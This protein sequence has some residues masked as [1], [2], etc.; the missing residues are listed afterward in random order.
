VRIHFI[1]SKSVASLSV[2]VSLY[3]G[4]AA[5]AQEVTTGTPASTAADVS[6]IPPLPPLALLNSYQ[7]MIVKEIR[8]RGIGDDRHEVKQIRELVQQQVG[9]P[10]DR[11][12]VRQSLKS[13]Y[14]TGRFQDLIVEAE[15]QS[16]QELTLVFVAEPN[17]F[18]GSITG[19]GGP[20][21]PADSQ[22]LDS[23][24]LQLGEVLTRPMVQQ[25]IERMQV[26]LRDNGYYRAKITEM[27]SIR[28]DVQLV[29][30]HFHIEPGP[31][32]RIGQISVEGDAGLSAHE[33]VQITGLKA[34]RRLTQ[35]RLT[36]GLQKLRK[37]YT[38][39]K[40]LESQI[41][42]ADRRYREDDNVV[43]FTFRIERGPV[44]DIAVEGTSVSSRQLRKLV[45]VFEENAVDEDLLN[46]GRRNIRDYLQ[47]QGYFDAKVNFTETTSPDKQ[48]RHIIYDVDRGPKHDVT[49][50][51]LEG[52]KY[53]DEDLIRER[54]LV[55]PKSIIL[56]H[57]RFSQAMMNQDV[58]SITALYRSNGFLE[59]HVE[60]EIKDDV[61]GKVGEMEVKYT[62]QEGPQTR[63]AHLKIEGNHSF[64]T[65]QI[66]Q[67]LNTQEG[68]AYSE[69]NIALDRDAILNFYF[70]K[71][72]PNTQ[73]QF[74][75]TDTPNIP[76]SKDVTFEIKE[77][78]QFFVDRIL[79]SQLHF[80]RPYVVENQF[81]IK[82]GDPL[83]QT[84]LAKTQAALYD[85]GVFNEVK[86]AVQNPDGE[87]KYKDVLIQVQEAKRWTF[88]YGFG[89]EAST[90]QPDQASC[91]QL[92]QQGESSLACSQGRTGVS[93][94]V[95]F[96]VSRINFRG[97]A[98]TLTLKSNVGRL[99]Q[100]GLISLEAPRWWDK[101][102]WTF[103]TTAFY[104]NSVNVTTFTSERLE[105]SLQ[106]EQKY[107]RA[108]R[109]LY[110]FTYR[111][112]KASNV[113]VSPDQIPLYSQPV[114]V[115]MPNFAYIRDKRDNV[116]DTQNG[117]FTTFDTGVASSIFGSQASFARFLVQNST[118]HP[119]GGK[120]A[121]RNQRWVFARSTRIGVEEPFANTIIPL[122]ERFFA[123]GSNSLRGFA[124]NQ[125]GPRDLTTGS[126]LG[127]YAVF[128]NSLELRTPP[129]LLPFVGDSLS[130]AFFHDAGNV[131]NDGQE[132]VNNIFRWHQPHTEYCESATTASKCNFAYISHAVG[133]GIRYRTPIGPIRIDVAY[134]LNPTVYPATVAGPNNTTAF[135]S[136]T[137][138][139]INVFFSI[140]QTF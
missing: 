103:T 73:F 79:T 64:P 86:M 108:S 89:L 138:R 116:I 117:N 128:V 94:R 2:L 35:D 57:G 27:E 127:G 49:K 96:D 90:G 109:F 47:T 21:H 56:T 32:A 124:L 139:R 122:P 120:K 46:E 91:A 67:L 123:G 107:S 72:F 42:I 61:G 34:G 6:A 40:R 38:S 87:A 82:P 133:M 125:A 18:I 97:K 85:L 134:N 121:N 28:A 52:N 135:Q 43:D 37:K 115:G 53:F 112:V 105:G 111:R 71:G 23:T 55:Q 4:T 9:Q 75:T 39:Q 60:G 14:A 51:T 7:G 98:N 63:V 84:Q 76:E 131:F 29:D 5:R 13:L 36:S 11:E 78:E 92:A 104:D 77:G 15:Q 102:N 110:R 66:L 44:V 100:R 33:L 19:D 26:I 119:F 1:L 17:Y 54:L 22:L 137:T 93:P 74:K 12:K 65:D 41:A 80:T 132:M 101:P 59:A 8:F 10:L 62:I 68:Q 16:P 114:R 88:N 130:F 69:S 140:G 20:K 45:P 81:Q 48:Q 3:M 31:Q 99:Q 83:S 136:F 95:S 70:D 106:L 118:Y 126:P 50:V 25:A 113:V 129:P 30:I 24:K 58:E